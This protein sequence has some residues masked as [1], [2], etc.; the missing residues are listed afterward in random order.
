[1]NHKM[2]GIVN[3]NSYGYNQLLGPLT[4]DIG[5]HDEISLAIIQ[6][7]NIKML[8]SKLFSMVRKVSKEISL[9]QIQRVLNYSIAEQLGSADLHVRSCTKSTFT[10][11]Q[12]K[13]KLI[14]AMILRHAYGQI[15]AHEKLGNRQTRD[16]RSVRLQKH[17]YL[18]DADFTP[19]QFFPHNLFALSIRDM[20]KGGD[21]MNDS[22]VKNFFAINRNPK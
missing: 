5:R 17:P 4:S 20:H 3:E 21:D 13:K 1:M 6:I 8:I 15:V 16:L 2:K 10:D 18:R 11:I 14:N 9:P 19:H 7:P 12:E 22:H